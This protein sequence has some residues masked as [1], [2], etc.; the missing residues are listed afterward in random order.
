M[1]IGVPTRLT[2][3]N[4]C[5]LVRMGVG[6]DRVDRVA[7]AKRGVTLCNVPGKTNQY[8][9]ETWKALVSL[10]SRLKLTRSSTADYGTSEIADHALALA[11]SLRRGVIHQHDIQ[12]GNPPAEWTYVPRPFVSRIQGATFGILGLGLIGTAV[13][14][15]AKAFGWRVLFY[16]PFTPNGMD[17]ALGIERTKDIKDLFRQ[18]TTVSVHCPSTP[19]TQK[20][21]GYELLSL[22]P[23]GGILINT[24]RGEVVDLDDVERCLREDIIAG[25][26]LDVVPNEPIPVEGP[27][28]PLLEAYRR[29]EDWLSGR[30]VVTPHSAYYSPE[31]LF[32]IRV[33]TAETMRDVL[34]NGLKVNIVHPPKV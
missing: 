30:M 10:Y 9:S 6:Y 21:V 28:H 4:A 7:L 32:D 3:F 33:K 18:S 8:L 25:V 23:K 29:H 1:F 22:M 2:R 31:S 11:L 15:R 14:Q 13:A 17:K 19:Q 27:I 5:S 12:R 26:G 34:I 20:L 24:A 16:D